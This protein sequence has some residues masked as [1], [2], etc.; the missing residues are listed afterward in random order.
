MKKLIIS[1]LVLLCGFVHAEVK[2]HQSSPYSNLAVTWTEYAEGTNKTVYV[3]DAQYPFKVTVFEVGQTSTNNA[4]SIDIVR[5]FDYEE[6]VV[7]EVTVTNVFGNAE[8]YYDTTVTNRTWKL[9]TNRVF[10]VTQTTEKA[11]YHIRSTPIL[12]PVYVYGD[13]VIVVN[14]SEEGGFYFKL[15]GEK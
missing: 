6:Q 14:H 9:M 5:A 7:G 2:I 8:T 10:S 1:G 11:V 13:D 4:I 12:P 15:T 3:N